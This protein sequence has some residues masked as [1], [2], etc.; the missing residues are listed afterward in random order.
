MDLIAILAAM[1]LN[2]S[3]GC[4]AL[5]AEV[6]RIG[7]QDYLIQSWS[8]PDRSGQPHIWRTWQRECVANNQTHFWGRAAFLE[9]QQSKLGI[10][11]NR[12]GEIQGGIG[13]SIEQAYIPLC[14]S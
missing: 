5:K 4:D 10:Y 14:G 8:C 2:A 6:T 7:S 9:D 11:V 12:F 13:A 1:L 3:T